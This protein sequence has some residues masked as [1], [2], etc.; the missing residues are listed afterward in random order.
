MNNNQLLFV[1]DIIKNLKILD[2]SVGDGQFL[3]KAFTLLKEIYE[4]FREMGIIKWKDYEINK[5]LVSCTLYGVDIDE[6]AVKNCRN[7][8]LMNF[9]CPENINPCIKKGNSLDDFD[10]EKEFPEVFEEGGYDIIIGNPPYVRQEKIKEFK[11][12]FSKKFQTFVGTAD[13]Y[14]YFIEKS[15]LLLKQ[16][17]Y[18]ANIVSNKFIKTRYGKK[19]RKFIL[20]NCKIIQY[21]D[22]F[23]SNVFQT[24]SVDPCIIIIK[25]D[26]NNIDNKIL[27]NER[28]YSNQSNL[29]ENAWNFLSDD[30]FILKNAIENKCILLKDYC[31]E[32]YSG[33]K[34]GLSD[35]L[36][37]NSHQINKIVGQNVNERELFIP[38]IRGKDI[39]RW[40]YEFQHQYLIYTEDIDINC[41][42]NI[43]KYFEMH[44]KRLSN[45]TDIK[46]TSKEWFQLRPCAYYKEFKKPKIIYPD[47]SRN[48]RFAFDTNGV[49]VNN[50]AYIIPKDDKFLLGVLNSR[51][52]EFYFQFLSVKLGKNGF[53]FIQQYVNL[54][55]IRE[56]QKKQKEVIISIVNLILNLYHNQKSDKTKHYIMFFE[57]Y[58]LNCLIYELYLEDFVDCNKNLYEMIFPILPELNT[59][60]N[61]HVFEML[62][63][64]KYIQKVIEK[65]K[66]NKWVKKIEENYI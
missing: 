28:Y 33:I 24:A 1:L 58:L 4:M 63:K 30:L 9:K 60:N 40:K 25:K 6:N 32:P 18:L 64:Q 8:L 48:C 20:E 55:P 34:T 11:P 19:I 14:V 35:V 12:I 31:G 43:K 41:F 16:G 44:R 52:I 61:Y 36:I 53:R 59:Q 15:I 26:T 56:P 57:N 46:N 62:I 38:F 7:R 65:I 23:K 29:D 37:V 39:S 3:V 17:G 66:Q 54:I 22:E 21:K 51:L 42:P 47:I 49:F 10:W 50:T 13:L 45:R 2:P 27:I 5:H